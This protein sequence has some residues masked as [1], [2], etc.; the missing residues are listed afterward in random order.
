MGILAHVTR[1]SDNATGIMYAMETEAPLGN[2]AASMVPTPMV[3]NINGK[4]RRVY[5][6]ISGDNDV[7]YVGKPS[8]YEYTFNFIWE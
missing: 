3:I 6:D 5:H 4:K 2:G 7:F 8:A 1:C